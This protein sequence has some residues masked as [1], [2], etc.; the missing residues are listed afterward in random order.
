MNEENAPGHAGSSAQSGGFTRRLGA[1]LQKVLSPSS[2]QAGK[3]AGGA[4]GQARTAGGQ[5]GSRGG[6]Q[7]P[8]P[9]VEFATA[10]AA[11]AAAETQLTEL[12]D[13][14]DRLRDERLA[15]QEE[16]GAQHGDRVMPRLRVEKT[17]GVPS[18]VVGARMM[19]RVNRLAD[20]PAAGTDG[21][22]TVFA[23]PAATAKF[24][25][26][27]GVPVADGPSGAA[28]GAGGS[29]LIV[30]AFRG[31][32]G[33]VEVRG[34]GGVRHLEPDGTDP[35][36][37][38]PGASYDPQLQAPEQLE[39]IC[40]WSGLL[41]AHVSRP[42]LQI[43]W[44]VDEGTPRVERIDVDPDRIPVLTPEWDRRLGS[45]FDGSYARFL[46]QPYR[47]GAL[48]NRVPGGTFDPEEHQ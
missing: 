12:T 2:G 48:A 10:Q 17:N 47:Q 29:A 21:A 43:L 4:K 32:V 28:Q 27:H 33:L 11:L 1:R 40:T 46:V 42:Y 31:E 25:R 41:S 14:R 38:R 37:I 36:D 8:D 22:G 35:G 18:F 19:Q 7:R 44:S 23:D 3:A 45:V 30:H 6:K 9:A 39:Q 20:D 15:L 5:R 16:L 26:S 24:V 13:E 34:A